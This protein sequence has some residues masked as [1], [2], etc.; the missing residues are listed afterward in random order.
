MAT[1]EKDRLWAV[2]PKAM[3]AQDEEEL[4]RNKVATNERCVFKRK[5]K[6]NFCAL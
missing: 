1:P 4:D 6:V 3:D 5:R 2:L